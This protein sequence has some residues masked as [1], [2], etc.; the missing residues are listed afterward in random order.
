M[1]TFLDPRYTDHTDAVTVACA[2][3]AARHQPQ[4]KQAYKI[5]L[6]P[7]DPCAPPGRELT[8]ATLQRVQVALA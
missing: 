6:S 5:N 3:P 1:Y 7:P 2:A 4:N 8:T